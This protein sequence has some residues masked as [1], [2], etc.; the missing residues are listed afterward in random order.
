MTNE[1]GGSMGKQLGFG[2]HLNLELGLGFSLGAPG[3]IDWLVKMGN[4]GRELAKDGIP[5]LSGQVGECKTD[6][7]IAYAAQQSV[8]IERQQIEVAQLFLSGK[9]Q[10][11]T[12]PPTEALLSAVYHYCQQNGIYY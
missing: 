6:T 11:F 3:Q 9:G 5:I 1:L 2:G 4:K 12:Q 8:Q 7:A 10:A